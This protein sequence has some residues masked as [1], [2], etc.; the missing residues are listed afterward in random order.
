[1]SHSKLAKFAAVLLA[2]AAFA[3]ANVDHAHASTTVGWNGDDSFSTDQVTFTG[4]SADQLSSISG[5]GTYTSSSFF[6]LF[7]CGCNVPVNTTF[8]LELRLNGVWTTVATWTLDSLSS[9]NLSSVTTPIN[10][11]TS[12]VS[13]IELT[14][15]PNLLGDNYNDMDFLTFGR[16]G[17]QSNEEDFTFNTVS[18]TPLPAALPLFAGGLGMIGLIGRRKKRKVQQG[19]A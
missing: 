10:F 4:F 18:S 17:I 7:G 15:T 9:I 5:D 19:I 8:D 14:A 2:C 3:V 16:N 13:G 1:M 12:L 11:A 6:D